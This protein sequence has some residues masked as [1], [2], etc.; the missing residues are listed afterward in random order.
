MVDAEPDRYRPRRAFIEP[1]PAPAPPADDADDADEDQPKPLYRE[2]VAGD[3]STPRPPV[4][5]SADPP[6]RGTATAATDPASRPITFTPRRTRSGDAD[7]TTLLPRVT[8]GR[9]GGEVDAIDDLSDESGPMGQRT[10]LALWI[11]AAVAVAVIGL[12]IGYA[13][14]RVGNP[15]TASTTPGPSVTVSTEPSAPTAEPSLAV[16]D[17][18]ALLS[19]QDAKLMAATNWKVASTERDT[20]ADSPVPACF[21]PEPVEGQPVP[22]ARVLRLLS[23]SGKNAPGLLHEATAYATP[24]E[25]AQAY[26]V[27]AKTLG[28]CQVAGSYLFSGQ[29]ITG[30]GEQAT[31][32]IVT[33]VTAG[34]SS[35]HSMVLSRTGRVLNI[36]DAT[37]PGDKIAPLAVARAAA[38]VTSRECAPAG[39]ACGGSVSVKD[40]PP[41]IG[42]DEPG[43]LATGDLPP[44][45]RTPMPWVATPPELPKEDFLGSQCE[46]LNW[47]TLPTEATTSRVYIVQDSANFFGL[48]DIVVTMKDKSA[49]TKLVDKIK[50]DLDSCDKRKLT[51]T[52]SKPAK[53]TGTGARRTEV[54]GYTAEVSQ[55]STDGTEKYRVGIVSAGTKVAYTFLNPQEGFD[56]TDDQWDTVAVRAG[57]RTTQVN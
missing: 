8:S 45:G 37:R 53:V 52:V 49:A 54:A 30:V 4:E 21:G 22:E 3:A 26:A 17:E 50:S 38:A 44:V 28:G 34:A 31:G 5:D 20:S 14:L 13:V 15:P 27:A 43:F 42:G 56:F 25:A 36:I 7:A 19:T 39:G 9:R 48:N 16:L 6:A 33:S 35:H 40:G 46:S 10:K 29:T 23:S 2:A 24:E 47:S 32:V 51:A 12:A 55:R 1:D 11:G 57:Q 18:D 41:P